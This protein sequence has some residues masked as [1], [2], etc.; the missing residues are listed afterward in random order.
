MRRHGLRLSLLAHICCL[1]CF[2]LSHTATA[3]STTAWV[4]P[5]ASYSSSIGVLG[6]K[7]DTDRIAYWPMAVD[8]DN[9]CVALTYEDRTVH[10]LRI[11]QSEGAYDVSYDAWNY[12]YTG[13]AATDKPTAGGAIEMTYE[14][15]DASKCDELVDTDGHKLPLSASNS[16]NYL[17]SCLDQNDTYVGENY[18]LYNIADSLCTLGFDEECELDYPAYNQASCPHT[19]G[20]TAA[21][22]NTPV[23]NINYPTGEK[24]LASTGEVVSDT[25]DDTSNADEESRAPGH[26]STFSLMLLTLVSCYLYAS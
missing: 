21:L 14:T 11:D 9:I 26:P 8:C 7:V 6:C 19:L 15:V 1:F 3:K 5:H 13:Y 24:V 16:M 2:F 22:N 25:A 23:Y 20:L 4:T 12:L 18:V 10:L 17:A